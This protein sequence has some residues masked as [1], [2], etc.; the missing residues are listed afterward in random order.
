MPAQNKPLNIPVKS[1]KKYT[2]PH[3]CTRCFGCR[4]FYST[5]LTTQ[6]IIGYN[7]KIRY[8]VVIVMCVYIVRLFSR[9]SFMIRKYILLVVVVF[10]VGC[11][12]VVCVMEK[13]NLNVF[14]D[15]LGFR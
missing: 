13:H 8:T 10:V 15:M 12:V 4:I 7:V 2:L 6:F 14:S 5:R 11:V 9:S 3:I 1:S